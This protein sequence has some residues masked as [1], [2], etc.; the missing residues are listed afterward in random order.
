MQESARECKRVQEKEKEKWVK[1][2]GKMSEKW[3]KER[4]K[5]WKNEGKLFLKKIVE[6]E[7]K[8]TVWKLAKRFES[9]LNIDPIFLAMGCLLLLS[10]ARKYC[11]REYG[12][13]YVL[14]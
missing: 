6:R 4:R 11:T 2:E 9:L 1:N 8:K 5:K 10:D 13:E 12:T 14:Q 7:R 3:R